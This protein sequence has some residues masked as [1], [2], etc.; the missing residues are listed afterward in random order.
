M[1]RAILCLSSG[2]KNCIVTASGIVT[3]CKRPY[4]APV[5]S[6][7]HYDARSEKHQ[8]T[9]FGIYCLKF[10]IYYKIFAYNQMHLL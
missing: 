3:L 4:S 1:F 9:A 7:L 10:Q 2:G 5:E 6:G 8:I